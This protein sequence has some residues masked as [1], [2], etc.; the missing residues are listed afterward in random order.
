MRSESYSSLDFTYWILENVEENYQAIGEDATYTPG[1]DGSLMYST[2]IDCA[3]ICS[4][5]V[6]RTLSALRAKVGRYGTESTVEDAMN[7]RGAILH[8]D[9]VLHVSVGDGKRLVGPDDSGTVSLYRMSSSN[10]EITYWD[11]AFLLPEMR[12]L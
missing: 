11:G 10:Q 9:G 8:K 4:V 7:T 1:A 12:Y 2:V 3:D 5:E 6:P